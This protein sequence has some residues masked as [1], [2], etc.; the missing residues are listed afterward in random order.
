MR[1]LRGFNAV[2]LMLVL[3][4][5][6]VLAGAAI[7][8]LAPITGRL[9]LRRA[10][11]ELY[12]AIEFARSSAIARGGRVLIAPD[13]PEQ[14]DWARGWVIFAD[15]DGDGQPGDGEE[16][17]Q[18]HGPLPSRV[19]AQS[20]FSQQ[21][22]AYIAYNGAGRSCTFAS[23][24]AARW[25]SVTLARDGEIRRIRIAMLGRARLCDPQNDASCGA[26]ADDD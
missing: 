26:P 17:L 2:E 3:A 24:T 23:S 19:R 21:G 6:A 1:R 7:P 11:A 13:E 16:I 8:N 25:G 10:A 15:R 12:G 22:A 9:A 5:L 14:R 20:A 4:V 18:R